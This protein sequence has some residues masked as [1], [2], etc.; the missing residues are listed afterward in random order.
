MEEITSV[1]FRCNG[2]Y[3]AKKRH[4]FQTI[5]SLRL[6]AASVV[7]LLS[8]GTI[9][10]HFNDFGN[11]YA[12]L[13]KSKDEARS[14]RLSDSF[15]DYSCEDIWEY[16][17]AYDYSNIN[18]QLRS[19][20]DRCQYAKE[21]NG[22]EG[23]YLPG[24]FCSDRWTFKQY[25][26]LVCPPLLFYLITLFRVLGS[27]AEDYFSPSLEM[28]STKLG[29]PPRFAGVSLLALG[30]GAADVSSTI[31]AITSDPAS[32]YQ[33]SLGALTGSS[34]FIGTVVAGAVIV[35]ADGVPC[36]GALI[37]DIVMYLITIGT[38]C[39]FLQSGSVGA[40]AISTFVWLY[41]AFVLVVLAAD[42]YH[43]KVTLPRAK[44]RAHHL[45]QLENDRRRE[46]Q[47]MD[48][49]I[50]ATDVPITVRNE[51]S[52]TWTHLS[53]NVGAGPG[54]AVID[55]WHHHPMTTIRSEGNR[56]NGMGSDEE[57]GG[58]SSAGSASDIPLVENGGKNASSDIGDD[59]SDGILGKILV[60]LSNYD[61]DTDDAVASSADEKFV[62]HGKNG[63]IMDKHRHQLGRDGDEGTEVESI[64]TGMSYRAMLELDMNMTNPCSGSPDAISSYNW[65]SAFAEA[66]DDL[67]THVNMCYD[68]LFDNDENNVVD[69][70]FLALELPFIMMRQLTVSV[71]SEGYY[72][73]PVVA[74]SLMLSPIWIAFYLRFNYDIDLFW[75]D[76]ISYLTCLMTISTFLGCLV[77][78][79]APVGPG[80][81]SLGVATPIALWGFIVAATWIDSVADQLVGLLGFFG[82]LL[83]I[84]GSIL[85]LTILAWGN[86]M[87]DLA[88]DVT[89]AK[90]GLAN[91]AITAC[92]A[93]PIFNMLIGLGSGFSVLL[94]KTGE[95][96]KEVELTSSIDA[97]FIFLTLNCIMILV[98][99]IFVTK[100][101][102]ESNFGYAAI[103]LYAL[104]LIVSLAL[105][106]TGKD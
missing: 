16:T 31:N 105:H 86:S 106:F 70:F 66:K 43:R 63:L 68:D 93:G 17:E 95:D 82:V 8:L 102:I 40:A 71:P 100:G 94:Q 24:L 44:L 65:S 46:T 42:V 87:G 53:S 58:S 41:I 11:G 90:K 5:L 76:G 26:W 36:R 14:R 54:H 59:G 74:L 69:K 4:R 62:L 2:T 18:E 91:M 57:S 72:C 6:T 9:C 25:S 33:M 67:F 55:E 45:Q 28:F 51:G 39:S 34:M 92:Y 97:G 35:T 61:A 88:A 96:K 1:A 12:L 7:V 37:R 32:G 78:R 30:N 84:P 10:Y 64:S 21:C 19:E 60:A 20:G 29:L 77:I 50:E 99:G 103:G 80:P 3:D 47:F 15:E 23:I 52:S 49:S 75:S 89:M 13:H 79:Y 56:G 27:T 81:M 85:G 38:I 22:G 48:H 83:R 73:R 98:G 101:R 104:Y